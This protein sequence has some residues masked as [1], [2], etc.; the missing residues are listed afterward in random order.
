MKAGDRLLLDNTE[1]ANLPFE[2]YPAMHVGHSGE[3][4][5]SGIDS[6]LI[7]LQFM[8]LLIPVREAAY[9][10]NLPPVTLQLTFELGELVYTR[11]YEMSLM[12]DPTFHPENPFT[13]GDLARCGVPFIANHN[14]WSGFQPITGEFIYTRQSPLQARVTYNGI[15]VTCFAT[16]VEAFFSYPAF[17]RFDNSEVPELTTAEALTT[18]LD[19]WLAGLQGM[20]TQTGSAPSAFIPVQ[21]RNE[22]NFVQVVPG[23]TLVA[24][25]GMDLSLR[26]LYLAEELSPAAFVELLA[27]QH[28]FQFEDF[29][30]QN[31]LRFHR[32][33]VH[34]KTFWKLLYLCHPVPALGG[35]YNG[36]FPVAYVFGVLNYLA[37]H[38]N[39]WK[40]L[41]VLPAG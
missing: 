40:T 11:Q 14:G 13:T 37:S 35:T 12:E 24:S 1:Y 21:F 32:L 30:S 3:E 6:S 9:Y 28:L 2:T 7:G 26:I 25:I 23:G 36:P 15:S 39:W 5:P 16:G 18:S 29:D 4:T 20:V 38:P 19:R 27:G 10:L 34:G 31:T 17:A 33:V 8:Q 22:H 41:G